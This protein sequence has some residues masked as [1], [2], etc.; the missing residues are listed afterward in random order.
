MKREASGW[1]G[2]NLINETTEREGRVN[3][4]CQKFVEDDHVLFGGDF[5]QQAFNVL[6]LCFLLWSFRDQLSTLQGYHVSG[7]GSNSA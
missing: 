7:S 3:I 4:H 1:G 5:V 6:L 2:G